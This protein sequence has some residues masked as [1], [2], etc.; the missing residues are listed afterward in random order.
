MEQLPSVNVS[1]KVLSGMSPFIGEPPVIFRPLGWTIKITGKCH[2][3]SW[4]CLWREILRSAAFQSSL[5]SVVMGALTARSWLITTRMK[6]FTWTVGM[7]THSVV[8]FKQ[9]LVE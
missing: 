6:R 3:K 5:M 1:H 9:G 4:I 2:W 7:A 8:S